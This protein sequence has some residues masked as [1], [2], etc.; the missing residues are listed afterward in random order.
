MAM[1]TLMDKI[2]EA[3]EKGKYMIGLFLDFSKA[4]DTVNHK[5]LIDKLNVYGIRGKA[6]AWVTS[7]LSN[8]EQYSTYNGHRSDRLKINCGVP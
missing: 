3:K 5:I 7:Y 8:R 1:L 2:I 6:N 4:F